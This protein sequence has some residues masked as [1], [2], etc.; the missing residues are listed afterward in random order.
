MEKSTTRS[1]FLL[2]KTKLSHSTHTHTA[3]GYKHTH[4][5]TPIQTPS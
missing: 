2:A 3:Y 4:I 5:H 1:D